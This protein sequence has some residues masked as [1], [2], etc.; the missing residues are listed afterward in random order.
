MSNLLLRAAALA[1]ALFAA[2]ASSAF[3]HAALVASTPSDGNRMP[4][5]PAAATLTFNEPVSPLALR[6]FGPLGM[7]VDVAARADG[8]S[9]RVELPP[10]TANGS[11][12]LSWRVASDDGHPVAGSLSFAVGEGP[13]TDVPAT[14][15]PDRASVITVGLWISRMFVYAGLL[16]GVGGALFRATLERA[17]PSSDPWTATCLST[18]IAGCI[19]AVGIQGCDLSGLGTAG[20]LDPGAW[21]KGAASPVGRSSAT[22]VIALSF[23]LAAL[24]LSGVRATAAALAGL[25][26]GAVS[27]ALSGHAATAGGWD[28]RLAVAVH[29]AAAMVWVGSLPPLVG[30]LARGH[31]GSRDILRRFSAAILPTVALLAGAG[32]WLSWKQGVAAVSAIGT[33]YGWIWLAKMAGV[34]ALLGIAAANRILFTPA[35]LRSAG[36]DARFARLVAVEACIAVAVLGAAAGW[37]FTPPPRASAQA[38]LQAARPLPGATVHIHGKEGMTLVTFARRSVGANSAEIALLKPEGG[39][40]EAKEVRVELSSPAAGIE[41]LTR[42]AVRRG[43]GLWEVGD[44]NLPA[45]GRWTVAVVALVSDFDQLRLEGTVPIEA[46]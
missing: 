39:K 11:Y 38:V 6:L 25:G 8:P 12:L 16:F 19:L 1:A 2:S 24:R 32:L 31:D 34:A 10:G 35:H 43:T 26:V 7:A 13:A 36:G 23:A 17:S 30:V 27:F 15:P 3:G 22:A 29:A 14:K 4:E 20:L 21:G 41:R 9:L 37:R 46:P 42:T 44:L 45:P 18:G 40:L 5:T 28:T 33:P